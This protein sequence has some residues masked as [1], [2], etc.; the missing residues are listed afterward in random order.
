MG[1]ERE[2]GGAEDCTLGGDDGRGGGSQGLG[3]E[4]RGGSGRGGSSVGSVRVSESGSAGGTKE[5]V[6]TPGPLVGIERP[7]RISVAGSSRKSV[8][9]IDL[10]GSTAG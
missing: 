8:R 9:S 7:W 3:S 10:V 4:R 1:L 2:E 5:A 6:W